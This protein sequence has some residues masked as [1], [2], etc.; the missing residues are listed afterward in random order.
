MN[1]L[2]CDAGV[3]R[4]VV[5]LR[6]G[7]GLFSFRV[8]LSPLCNRKELLRRP[9]CARAA[10]P[11]ARAF[12]RRPVT[13]YGL[14]CTSRPDADAPGAWLPRLRP[15]PCSCT[16]RARAPAPGALCCRR[17]KAVTGSVCDRRSDGKSA[18]SAVASRARSTQ[19][20]AWLILGLRERRAPSEHTH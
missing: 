18:C 11:T 2:T 8:L 16:R 1:D 9:T 7:E 17:A 12:A 13:T 5:H 6:T 19:L 15:R 10:A 14:A 4:E 20:I 3:A